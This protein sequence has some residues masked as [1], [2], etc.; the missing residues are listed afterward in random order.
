MPF[1][2]RFSRLM[3]PM[4]AVCHATDARHEV[5]RLKRRGLLL[6]A[7]ALRTFA[8]A[9]AATQGA[10]ICS[11]H[12]TRHHH[13]HASAAPHL[14]RASRRSTAT[15]RR[16]KGACCGSLSTIGC[17]GCSAAASA[18]GLFRLQTTAATA[19]SSSRAPPHARPITSACEAARG[20]GGGG[21]R[22]AATYLRELLQ[23]YIE[24]ILITHCRASSDMAAMRRAPSASRIATATALQ[25]SCGRTSPPAVL[26]TYD[27]GHSWPRSR[28]PPAT[29]ALEAKQQVKTKPKKNG[30]HLSC[31]LQ[32]ACRAQR[33]A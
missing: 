24:R 22:S 19:S 1:N 3:H 5:P 20:G 15:N 14:Q 26:A 8:P 12:R 23:K 28:K 25:M 7:H 32:A 31:A 30:K 9:A 16:H 2:H 10:S 6:P 18:R 29:R 21:C 17:S 33:P 11:F 4:A 13:P 27:S